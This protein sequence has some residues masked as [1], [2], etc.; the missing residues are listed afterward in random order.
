MQNYSMSETAKEERAGA[1]R[2][3]LSSKVLET[4]ILPLNYAPCWAV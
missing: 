4:S 1:E 3:E 2:I